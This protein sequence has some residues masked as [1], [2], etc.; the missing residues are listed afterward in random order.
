MCMLV[1][2]KGCETICLQTTAEEGDSHLQWICHF[3]VVLVND[4]IELASIFKVGPSVLEDFRIL[5]ASL[6]PES[7]GY[8]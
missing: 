5:P 1:V 2:W 4:R 3:D 7:S 8:T 6:A